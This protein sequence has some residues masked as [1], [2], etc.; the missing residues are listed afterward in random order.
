M[1]KAKYLFNFIRT[2]FLLSTHY[3]HVFQA[4]ACGTAVKAGG[5]VD[6]QG[7]ADTKD[8]VTGLD[9]LKAVKAMLVALA[10]P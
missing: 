4:R 9:V 3:L 5:R 1:L 7:S 8:P 6:P 10:Y 2:R